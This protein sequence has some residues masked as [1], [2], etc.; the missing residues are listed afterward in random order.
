MTR[1]DLVD[2][3]VHLVDFRQESAGVDALV[4]AM[5]DAGVSSA[6]VFGLPYKK[7][8]SWDEPRPPG[9]YLDDEA[10]VYPWVA[11]DL[12]ILD[13]IDASPHADRFA[14]TVNGVD[15]TDLDSADRVDRLLGTG[16]F[17]GVGE[18]LLRHGRL[19]AHV[20][21]ERPR[22]NHP[23]VRRILEVCVR[24]GVPLALHQNAGSTGQGATAFVPEM[25]EL[26]GWQDIVPIVWCHAGVSGEH[27]TE[28]ADVVDDL[29]RRYPHLHVDLSWSVLDGPFEDEHISGEWTDLIVAHPER[30]V[31]GSDSVGH[32]DSLSTD[33]AAA[34]RLLDRL[35]ERTRAGLASANARRLW[36]PAT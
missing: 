26:L 13:L 14:V 27:V 25:E 7:R 23:G 17:A 29:L 21:T 16:R 31:W 22:A 6:V 2:A 35:P 33:A 32:F 28:N 34:R 12:E 20:A 11:G 15:P 36:F 10:Q 5:D 18:L 9:Y 30:F 3:H 8:W 24:H 1:P 19:S 4:A